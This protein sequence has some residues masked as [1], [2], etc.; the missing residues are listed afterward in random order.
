[1]PFDAP[2]HRRY[3][4][5]RFPSLEIHNDGGRVFVIFEDGEPIDEFTAVENPKSQSVSEEFAHRRAMAYF[6]RMAEGEMSGEL[7]A[8]E[9]PGGTATQINRLQWK[10]KPPAAG[11]AQTAQ[12]H[13]IKGRLGSPL[14]PGTRYAEPKDLDAFMAQIA[15]E[16]DP[17]K[18]AQMKKAALSW[19]QQESAA[20]RVVRLLLAL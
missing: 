13:P 10:S 14:P 18:A 5:E 17:Q 4:D 12:T 15:Q 3:T 16:Q 7:Q 8:R 11:A 6:N 9:E 2:Q 1:M 20:Q 19:M